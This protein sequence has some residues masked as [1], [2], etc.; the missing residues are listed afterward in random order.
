[1]AQSLRLSE[2]EKTEL[3]EVKQ[4]FPNDKISDNA[5]IA[6]LIMEYRDLKQE[7]STLKE[8]NRTYQNKYEELL[9]AVRQKNELLK[10]F[11]EAEETLNNL[12]NKK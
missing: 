1:M 7:I 10:Q 12:V 3:A 9:R 11:H 4:L 6:H 2:R 8:K 5:V